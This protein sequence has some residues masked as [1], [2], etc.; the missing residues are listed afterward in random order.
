M[1]YLHYAQKQSCYILLHATLALYWFT[2]L[3]NV[4]S[5]NSFVSAM[6]NQTISH[7]YTLW[8]LVPDVGPGSVVASVPKHFYMFWQ[9]RLLSPLTP[10]L[11]LFKKALTI[12]NASLFLHICCIYVHLLYYP[13]CCVFL[14]TSNFS[15]FHFTFSIENRPYSTKSRAQTE[16]TEAR[17]VSAI[18]SVL[19][20]WEHQHSSIQSK[21]IN[22]KVI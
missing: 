13:D 3:G 11:C 20:G 8:T 7:F 6:K 9:G 18:V 2:V 19:C 22:Q 14:L 17:I 15:P 10:H 5:G 21:L 4:I 12:K 16:V 1:L